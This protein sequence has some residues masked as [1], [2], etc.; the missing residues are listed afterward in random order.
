M[1]ASIVL[2]L[3]ESSHFDRIYLLCLTNAIFH[4]NHDVILQQHKVGQVGLIHKTKLE[5]VDASFF[6]FLSF[7]L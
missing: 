5:T 3:G 4:S 2:H 7:C 6:L 1:K